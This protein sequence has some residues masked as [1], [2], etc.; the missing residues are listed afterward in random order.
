MPASRVIGQYELHTELAA[1]GMAT[2]YLGRRTSEQAIVAIKRLHEHLSRGDADLPNVL[3][4]E[5]RISQR[6][7][8]PNVVATLDVVREGEELLLVMEYVHGETVARLLRGVQI[9]GLV[10]PT[11]IAAAIV[12]GVLQGLEAAHNTK[13]EQGRALEIVHRDV[14]P[15][16]II[17]SAIDG[18]ARILDFGIAKAVGTQIHTRTGE[19]KGK[20][21]YM[22]PEILEG[23]K[24]TPKSDVWAAAV[25]LWELLCSKRLFKG[26]SEVHVWGQVLNAPIPTIAE[27]IGAPN[28]LDT[29]LRRALSRD[30][31]QGFQ[32]AAELANAITAATPLASPTEVRAWALDLA[33]ESLELRLNAV[34]T[35]EATL[36]MKLPPPKVTTLPLNA[37]I[38]AVALPFP[39]PSTEPEVDTSSPSVRSLSA[40]KAKSRRPAIFG[41]ALI[42][43]AAIVGV[44]VWQFRAHAESSGLGRAATVEPPPPPTVV[45]SPPPTDQTA[46]ASA[47]PPPPPAAASSA[48]RNRAKPAPALAPR[49]VGPSSCD[50]PYVIDSAGRKIFKLE[51]VSNEK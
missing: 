24:A 10:C 21:P 32:T 20:I 39:L 28:A 8:H 29:V 2:V 3:L 44:S 12:H 16:N 27:V 6:I 4:E 5:G 46:V 18:V 36:R 51:C 37:P 48:P 19:L 14:S 34:S 1:G 33:K 30:R 45:A 41:A 22:A 13:D 31:S 9:Q 17:V 50:P 23:E 15:Q 11:P 7:V 35:F 38:K 47:S 25:V 26:E 49:K 43:A 42:V 40:S